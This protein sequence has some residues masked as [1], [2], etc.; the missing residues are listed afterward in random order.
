MCIGMTSL[1]TLTQLRSIVAP[2]FSVT[3][4]PTVPLHSTLSTY[5]SVFS[6]VRSILRLTQVFIPVSVGPVSRLA[7]QKFNSVPLS[8]QELFL[9]IIF[10]N[11]FLLQFMGKVKKV[12]S[13]QQFLKQDSPSLILSWRA[14]FQDIDKKFFFAS[15][16]R[17][18]RNCFPRDRFSISENERHRNRTK[19]KIIGFSKTAR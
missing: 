1:S 13:I 18:L 8:K 17:R 15:R 10:Q 4:I 11:M 3:S 5:Q 9:F 6:R 7:K 16:I 19:F 14:D 2:K 12:N